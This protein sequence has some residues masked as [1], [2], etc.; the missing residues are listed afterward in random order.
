MWLVMKNKI[1]TKQNLIVRGWVGDNHCPFCQQPEVVDHLFL[2]CSITQQVWF[3]LGHNQDIFSQWSICGDIV[4]YGIHLPKLRKIG[5]FL[6]F[7]ALCWTIWKSRNDI[8]F[9]RKEI[10]SIRTLILL[11]ISLVEYWT[12]HV[13]KKAKEATFEWLPASLDVIPLR[14]WDPA[15]SQLVLYQGDQEEQ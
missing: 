12:G 2:Q 11:I 15:D 5:F 10:P 13:P 1:L 14:S 4:E 7:S 3:W 6:I 9:N 8:C